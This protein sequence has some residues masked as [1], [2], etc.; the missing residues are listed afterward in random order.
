M[1][2]P[3]LAALLVAWGS[4][5]AAAA[6]PGPAGLP[7]PVCIDASGD[8]LVEVHCVVN[9]C[10]PVVVCVAGRLCVPLGAGPARSPPLP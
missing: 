6:D 4:A 3:L 9:P 1:N 5:P 7:D 2:A 8:C 10:H